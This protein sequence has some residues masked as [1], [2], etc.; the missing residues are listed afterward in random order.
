MISTREEDG[1][2]NAIV[3]ASDIELEFDFGVKMN[4]V[5]HLFF[6]GIRLKILMTWQ[7]FCS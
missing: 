7:N 1:N 4:M 3:F 5:I 2:V 6:P